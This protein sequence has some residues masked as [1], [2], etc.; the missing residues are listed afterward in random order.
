M[1]TSNTV[2][3]V[4]ELDFDTIKG[5]L[6]D[7]LR[8]Q[9]QFSD[10]DFEGSGLNILLDILAY[11]THYMAYYLN[12]VGN[13]M[14]LDSA[15]LRDSV[16]SHAKNLNYVP[17]S[18]KSA[19]AIV[20]ILATDT[21]STQ[22]TLTIPAFTEFQSQQVDGVNYTFVTLSAQTASRNV[23][24]NTFYFPSV[25]LKQGEKLTYNVT[26][27]TTNTKRRYIIPN[28][29]IDTSTLLV[30]VQNSNED[31]NRE[32]YNL[33][34]DI[35][36]VTGNSKV[37]FLD[38]DSSGQ[39]AIYFGDGYIGKNLANGNIV[40]LT[41]LVNDG[42][43]PNKANS[44]TIVN[45]IGSPT[46][47]NV[48]VTSISSAAAGA[49]KETT[50][51]IKYSAP[52]FYTTQNR[53]V[54]IQDYGTLLVKDYPNIKSVSIWGGEDNDPIQYG[55]V[56]I[57]IN[58]KSG[59]AVT[60]A[61][62]IRI[63]N[64]M[65][66]NRNVLT[67][68][69]EIIDPDYIFLKVNTTVHYDKNKTTLDENELKVLISN[70]I[71][72]YNNTDL[73]GFNS[74][75]RYSKLQKQIDTTEN[76]FLSSDMFIEAQKRFTPTA[77]VS[78]NY[79]LDYNLPLKR[80]TYKDKLYS[81]PTFLISDD[82]G[83]TRDAYIEETPLSF[84]GIDSIEIISAGVNYTTPPT[85][86]ITGDGSGAT[87]VAKIVNGRVVSISVVNKGTNY[88]AAFVSITGDGYGATARATL[89][90]QIGTLRT[91]YIQE[92]TGEK[93][94]INNEAGEINYSTGKIKLIGFK[95]I[96]VNENPNYARGVLTINVQP[97]ESTLHPLRNRIIAIDDDD[98]IALQI[99]MDDQS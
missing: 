96:H 99:H 20:D 78:K 1:A 76:S 77:N 27:N 14:F 5:N 28:A 85:V 74:T 42:D 30:S 3:R 13:E 65:V 32:T 16:V 91:Y 87:A 89:S 81:Y 34:D 53:S 31:S 69:P 73:G 93:I 26:V 33:S 46:I 55:K 94:F 11:N 6:R 38:E 82:K 35:T 68:T 80:G 29:N 75:F 88:T 37:Y 12:M 17:S 60:E 24:S 98:P 4:A 70:T 51:S 63:I 40:Q 9:S 50:D 86:K 56:F 95:P 72:D 79:T 43:L 92:G 21:E 45:E 84:T 66:K 57:S 41:Y 25:Q 44:F 47:S 58:P 71:R 61:E 59:Y 83:V 19:V 54:T 8:N 22:S 97:E 62:K 36:T 10:Y 67:V 18:S 49:L 90:G 48:V 39:F 15:I 64:E 52:K 23:S 2:L 7:Y